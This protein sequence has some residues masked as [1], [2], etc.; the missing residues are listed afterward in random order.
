M[1]ESIA[2]PSVPCESPPPSPS[3]AR[4]GAPD[5]RVRL[6]ELALEL[7]RSRNRAV[8]VEYLRLRRALR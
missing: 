4:D 2:S 3:P 1:S 8:L 5:L 6:N 7:T